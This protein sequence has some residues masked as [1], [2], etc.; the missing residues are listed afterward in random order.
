[1]LWHEAGSTNF[2]PPCRAGTPL[3]WFSKNQLFLE[4]GQEGIEIPGVETDRDGSDNDSDNED[5]NRAFES[6][7]HTPSNVKQ[8]TTFQSIRKFGHAKFGFE[9][10]RVEI[11]TA[12]C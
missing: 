11:E 1:M 5:A 8:L 7:F 6:V 2:N 9:S 3:K 4:T 12:L 10:S